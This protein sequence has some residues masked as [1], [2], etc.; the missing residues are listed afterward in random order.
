MKKFF[1]ILMYLLQ[2]GYNNQRRAEEQPNR[3]M[4]EARQRQAK[5]F[6]K[7]TSSGSLKL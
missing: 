3:R 1:E 2:P 7:R 6:E 5:A 4:E